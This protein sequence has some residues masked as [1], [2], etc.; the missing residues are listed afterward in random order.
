MANFYG[1]FSAHSS[2]TGKSGYG[3]SAA[4]PSSRGEEP[5][6]TVRVAIK[7]VT[8]H[9][10]NTVHAAVCIAVGYTLYCCSLYRSLL[11]LWSL[12][13]GSI[14]SLTREVSQVWCLLPVAGC[15]VSCQSL[16]GTRPSTEFS[17]VY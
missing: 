13:R 2:H 4:G 12:N 10:A 14:A 8:P 7:D 9:Q 11:G 1:G 15:A 16:A 17:T 6:Q 5:G 3:Y